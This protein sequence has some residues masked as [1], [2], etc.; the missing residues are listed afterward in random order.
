MNY[1]FSQTSLSKSILAGLATGII[2]TV[3]NLVYNFIFR[4]ITKLSLLVSVINVTTVI[5]A[6][7]LLCIVASFVYHFI[8]FYLK[9]NATIYQ[10]L[11][12]AITIIA[13]VLG[14]N[15]HRSSN[16]NI[17]NQFDVLYL[18]MVVITGLSM[19]L[20]IPWLAKHKNVFFD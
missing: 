13:I 9:K 20:F 2:A 10:V 1:D 3:A 11:F 16:Q 6:S 14:L 8:V 4:G 19:T 5:F 7:I 15:F 18:G 17:S 12:I